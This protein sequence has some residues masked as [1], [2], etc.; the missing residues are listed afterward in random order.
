[1]NHAWVEHQRLKFN[2]YFEFYFGD[3]S[4]ACA[5]EKIIYRSQNKGQMLAVF[6]FYFW[7]HFN[8]CLTQMLDLMEDLDSYYSEGCLTTLLE[9]WKSLYFDC[10]FPSL[11]SNG[12]RYDLCFKFIVCHMLDQPWCLESNPS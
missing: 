7:Q 4:F 11:I 8:L 3:L 1:V 5:L 9:R 2:F 10:K 12:L 6:N